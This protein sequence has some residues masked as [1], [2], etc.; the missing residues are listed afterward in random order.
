MKKF[1]ISYNKISKTTK[2]LTTIK[3]WLVVDVK[4]KLCFGKQ[5]SYCINLQS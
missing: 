1:T 3:G 5:P 4:L 2:A